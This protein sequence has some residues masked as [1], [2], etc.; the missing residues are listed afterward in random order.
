MIRF[1]KPLGISLTLRPKRTIDKAAIFF[2]AQ[3]YTFDDELFDDAF[4]V[5]TAD[6]EACNEIFSS[7]LRGELVT[8][9]REI[10]PISMNDEGLLVRLPQVPHDPTIVPRIV[11]SYIHIG[12]VGRI[13]HIML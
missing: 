1:P 2:G 3:D 9:Q 12:V 7:A 10:V 6:G 8:L 11:N 4:L 13:P 5:K